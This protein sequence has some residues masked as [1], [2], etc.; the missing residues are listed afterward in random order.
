MKQLL[1]AA[2]ED[3]KQLQDHDQ[4]RKVILF[5]CGYQVHGRYLYKDTEKVQKYASVNDVERE[6]LL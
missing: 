3:C 4:M 6:K 5:L 1:D 2:F